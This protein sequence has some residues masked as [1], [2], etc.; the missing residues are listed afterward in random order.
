VTN[1]ITLK[2]TSPTT[3]RMHATKY[4][5]RDMLISRTCVKCLHAKRETFA[6]GIPLS[7]K[8][9]DPN[10]EDITF[11]QFKALDLEFENDISKFYLVPLT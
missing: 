11:N 7:K 1:D 10:D 2:S 6:A 9:F 5:G 3:I 8:G 4:S